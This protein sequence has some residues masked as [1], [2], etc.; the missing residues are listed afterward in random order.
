MHNSEKG[1]VLIIVLIV[2]ALM[3]A[4]VVEFAGATYTAN[5]ALSNWRDAQR[6]SL[7]ARSG[8]HIVTKVVSDNYDRY[9][10][11]YPGSVEMP[12]PGITDDFEGQL[13]I[14]ITDENAKFNLNSLVLPN[15]TLNQTAYESFR[16]L[17]RILALDENIA[18]RVADWIDRDTEPRIGQS[19]EGA[20]NTY[21]DSVDELWLIEDSKVCEKLLPFVTVYGMGEI[22][23]NI[24]N[25]NTASVTVLMMLDDMMTDELAG[26]IESYRS[27]E[28]FQ[29]T[30]D[31]VKV[32]GF[33]GSLGQSLIG[34]IAVK[35]S[36]FRVT[37]VAEQ[38]RM[39]RIIECVMEKSAG[40]FKVRYWQEM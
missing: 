33:E 31:I 18:D 26:R 14:K 17:L 21:M 29:K 24:I 34:R 3:T 7:T 36:N 38:N 8:I 12:V 19:E 30:S 23:A 6:L 9:S 35:A 11:T 39:K 28:P 25:I 22:S 2:M 16:R 40:G 37:S 20:K 27:L 5:A 32:A 15:S 10:Y 1:M 4:M 13:L